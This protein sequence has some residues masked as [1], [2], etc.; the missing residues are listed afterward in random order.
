MLR[1][2]LTLFSVVALL[3]TFSFSAG[4]AH[5]ATASSQPSVA[6]STTADFISLQKTCQKVLVQLN[7]AKHTTR[8]LSPRTTTAKGASPHLYRDGGC[9][10]PQT[11]E[12]DSIDIYNYNY[13]GL[14]C[15]AG[16]G[17]LGVA[18]YQVNEVENVSSAGAWFRWY[19]G[20]SG[21]F[22]PLPPPYANGYKYTFGN[23]TTNVEITQLC[24]GSSIGGHC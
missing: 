19:H 2:A 24:S 1:K 12:G 20:G 8:C 22:Q 15:F 9:S 7:G 17:Y 13:S 11:F 23:G 21:H 18:I 16:S 14:L 6:S 3:L 5:A 10:G 4:Q